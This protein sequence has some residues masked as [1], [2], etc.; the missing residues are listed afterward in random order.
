MDLEENELVKG[1]GE[2]L[3]V[4]VLLAGEGV[5]LDIEGVFNN[6]VVIVDTG[7]EPTSEEGGVWRARRDIFPL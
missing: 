2:I 7:D 6:G 4:D 5:M 1:H 3:K